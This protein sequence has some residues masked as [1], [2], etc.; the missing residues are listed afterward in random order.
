MSFPH[1]FLNSTKRFIKLVDSI[2]L[3][4]IWSSP[5]TVKYFSNSGSSKFIFSKL[6]KFFEFKLLVTDRNLYIDK[7]VTISFKSL[8]KSV[9][10]KIVDI[11]FPPKLGF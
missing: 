9:I 10:K 11:T 5:K 1:L 2:Y 7:T 8:L 4:S 6:I 3:V